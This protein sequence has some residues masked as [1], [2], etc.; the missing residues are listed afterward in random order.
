MAWC[1]TKQRDNFTFLHLVH[2]YGL[3]LA[4]KVTWQVLMK[5]SI[6]HFHYMSFTVY[7]FHSV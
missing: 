6:W 4:S 5:R 1:F 3:V 2:L 7:E